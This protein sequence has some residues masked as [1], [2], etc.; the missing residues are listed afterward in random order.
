MHDSQLLAYYL[1]EAVAAVVIAAIVPGCFFPPIAM[2]ASYST[3]SIQSVD[4][5]WTR[6]LHIAVAAQ[7]FSLKSVTAMSH[8][9]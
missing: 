2:S 4:S 6:K 3:P 8:C 9:F 7:P 5:F 1:K